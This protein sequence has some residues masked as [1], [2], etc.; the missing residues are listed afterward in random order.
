MLRRL[1][2]TWLAG[3]GALLLVMSMSGV[4]GAAPLVTD[5]AQGFVDL[6]GNGVA[7]S[8]QTLVV[9]DPAAAAAAFAAVDTNGDGAISVTEAAHSGWTGG[10]NCNH[11]GFVSSVAKTSADICDSTAPPAADDDAATVSTTT[12]T[13]GDCTAD[14]A[15]A[16][17]DATDATAP[18]V[19]PVAPVT[20]TD[21]AAPVDTSPNAHGKA[22]ATVAQSDAVRG[23]NC[24]HGGAVSEAAKKDHGGGTAA[25]AKVHGKK[26][27][28]GH[29]KGHKTQS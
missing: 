24:N 18:A 12:P 2:A 21:P 23:K 10:K 29:G 15:E 20:P 19:C 14:P 9:P 11:G 28:H 8:C 26:A 5:T 22:V 4:A 27:N 7:D 6:D 1:R 3:G 25:T 13:A 17:P 16:A